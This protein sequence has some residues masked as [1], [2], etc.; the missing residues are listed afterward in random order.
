MNDEEDDVGYA[1]RQKEA[2][3]KAALELADRLAGPVRAHDVFRGMGCPMCGGS[4]QHFIRVYCHGRHDQFQGPCGTEGEHLH[5]K[6]GVCGYAWKEDTLNAEVNRDK[7]A[8]E[9]SKLTP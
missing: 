5:G 9:V 4:S 1:E 3:Q 2:Q 8:E 7:I 6:C